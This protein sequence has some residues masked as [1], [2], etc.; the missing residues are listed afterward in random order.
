MTVVL[1]GY[2]AEAGTSQSE[3]ILITRDRELDCQ[4]FRGGCD[5][6]T[7][8]RAVHYEAFQYRVVI[9]SIAICDIDADSNMVRLHIS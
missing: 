3:E 1:V 4:E 5:G 6:T 2:L 7:R 8:E 9:A